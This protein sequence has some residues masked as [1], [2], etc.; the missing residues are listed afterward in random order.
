[1]TQQHVCTQQFFYLNICTYSVFNFS[2]QRKRIQC[3]GWEQG[4]LCAVDCDG[5]KSPLTHVENSHFALASHRG[6]LLSEPSRAEE[7][8]CSFWLQATTF[9]DPKNAFFCP[10]NM[11]IG[12]YRRT[13]LD[14]LPAVKLELNGCSFITLKYYTFY[15]NV[16]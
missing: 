2:S 5:L 11:Y 14:F 9:H 6:C 7:A 13:L 10:N 16:L 15:I 3:C 12:N 1:M 4:L 8:L